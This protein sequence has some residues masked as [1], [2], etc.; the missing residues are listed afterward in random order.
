MTPATATVTID[1]HAV[2][3]AELSSKL[4][5]LGDVRAAHIHARAGVWA[6]TAHLGVT[7]RREEMHHANADLAADIVTLE[8]EIDALRVEL[9][10]EELV[11][12]IHHGNP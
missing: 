1:R 9:A 12:R 2:L 8:A 10:H 4:R 7:E 6:Q 5:E 11:T 3:T